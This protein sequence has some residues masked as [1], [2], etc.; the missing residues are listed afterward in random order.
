MEFHEEV[1]KYSQGIQ[2]QNVTFSQRGI[3]HY[4]TPAIMLYENN[5]FNSCGK[6]I[7]SK[8]VTPFPVCIDTLNTNSRFPAPY[9]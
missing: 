6:D 7:S 3:Q 8:H 5:S 2:T 9:H 1:N 4:M